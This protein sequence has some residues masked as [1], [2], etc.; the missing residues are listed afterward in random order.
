[1]RLQTEQIEILLFYMFT[2]LSLL[3]RYMDTVLSFTHKG[4]LA[5]TVMSVVVVNSSNLHFI[6]FT[7]LSALHLLCCF[8]Q[9]LCACVY[10]EEQP[11]TESRENV[12]QRD[13]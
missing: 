12:A 3:N 6:W 13:N 5:L 7:S 1:M 8:V 4:F 11:N 9:S 2:C 10:A